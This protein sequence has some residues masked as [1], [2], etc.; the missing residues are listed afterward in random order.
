[1]ESI[2]M[3]GWQPLNGRPEFDPPWQRPTTPFP[4]KVKKES[5]YSPRA[6]FGGWRLTGFASSGGKRIGSEK[7]PYVII[8]CRR[9]PWVTLYAVHPY[10]RAS[11]YE[12]VFSRISHPKQ[13][14]LTQAKDTEWAPP[15]RALTTW[16]VTKRRTEAKCDKGRSITQSLGPRSL[17]LH[18]R[19]FKRLVSR[20]QD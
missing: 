8:A 10:N 16:K 14:E 1:L 12:C 20:C 18:L 2:G 13:S 7:T 6:M 4:S 9:P 11:F 5:G 19:I 15:T 3:A 17:S